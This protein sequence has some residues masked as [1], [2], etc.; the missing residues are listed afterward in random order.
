[1]GFTKPYPFPY[2]NENNPPWKDE[3]FSYLKKILKVK[4]KAQTHP[5]RCSYCR[6]Y[7]GVDKKEDISIDIEHIL[8]K[9]K[10]KEYSFFIK[11][12]TLACKRCNMSIKGKRLDF[13]YLKRGDANYNNSLDFELNNYKFL[14]PNL[15][16]INAYIKY[17][18]T[19]DDYGCV[20]FYQLTPLASSNPRAAFT[21]DFFR[22]NELQVNSRENYQNNDKNPEIQDKYNI[23]DQL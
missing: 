15:E 4:L 16:N 1:M 9:E 6:R 21:Y 22:L 14:H 5:P 13:L 11:N 12:L 18:N 17:S 23:P 7:F 3:G 19:E 10:Y 2:H 8:P 20:L